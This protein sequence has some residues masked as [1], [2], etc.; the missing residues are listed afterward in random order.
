[1]PRHARLVAAGFPMPVALRGI[2]GTAMFFAESDYRRFSD[3]LPA[4]AESE[5][6]RVHTYVLMT[7]HVHLLKPCS[8]G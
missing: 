5:S 4:L 2:E 6:V 8:A 3:I 1:M 7:D